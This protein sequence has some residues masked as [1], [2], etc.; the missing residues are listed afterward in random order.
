MATAQLANSKSSKPNGEGIPLTSPVTP[1]YK[2]TSPGTIITIN[3]V[4]Y[5]TL[6][7]VTWELADGKVL[8]ADIVMPANSLK[9]HFDV[10]PMLAFIRKEQMPQESIENVEVKLQKKVHKAKK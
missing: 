5:V 7:T 4:E 6:H 2:P 9:T 3:D 1:P 8:H 10:R